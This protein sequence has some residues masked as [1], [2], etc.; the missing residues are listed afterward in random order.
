MIHVLTKAFYAKD[1]VMTPVKV[2][3]LVVVLNFILNMTLIWTALGT[4]A[5]AWS[6]AI[7]AVLQV[8][9]LMVLIRRHISIPVDRAVLRS[10]GSTSVL[11]LIMGA[12]VTVAMNMMWVDGGTWWD[13]AYCLAACVASGAVTFFVGSYVMKMDELSWFFGRKT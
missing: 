7:C 13:S 8:S 3:I 5:L 4:S 1:D 6:T 12:I 9:I 11:T 2:A 10:W